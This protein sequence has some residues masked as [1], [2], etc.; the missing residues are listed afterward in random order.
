M[1]AHNGKC[2][3][4]YIL[5]HK[6]RRA[7][8]NNPGHLL[9]T[10]ELPDNIILLFQPPYC[11]EANPTERVWKYIKGFLARLVFSNLDELRVK[12]QEILSHLT[13]Y[14]IGFLTGWSGILHYLGFA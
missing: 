8:D 14:V 12:L 7:V 9:I 2:I 3:I 6:L 1:K 4:R 10:S 13:N 11:P 5:H